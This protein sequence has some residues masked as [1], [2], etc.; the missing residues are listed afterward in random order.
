MVRGK[1]I[2]IGNTLH[3]DNYSDEEMLIA[4]AI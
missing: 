3:P 2:E 4:T 1:A